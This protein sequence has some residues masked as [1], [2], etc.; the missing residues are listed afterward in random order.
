M[1]RR[2]NDETLY[3]AFKDFLNRC[4]LRNQSLLC[5]DKEA[6]TRENVT[7][8]KSR[9]VDSPLFGSDLS[10]EQKL[11][12]QMKG[13]SPEQ[14]III[15]DIYYLYFLP[16]THIGF[17]KKER[18]IR[19]AAEGSGCTFPDLRRE[20]HGSSAYCSKGIIKNTGSLA[21]IDFAISLRPKSKGSCLFNDATTLDL[22]LDNM[23]TKAD[24]AY[25]MRHA[26]LYMAFPDQYE[27]IISS[28]DKR[29]IVDTY[30]K[31][32][33]GE[34][35]SDI[36]EAIRKV[37]VVLSKRFENLNRPFDF[38]QD[39]KTEWRPHGEKPPT[40]TVSAD[41]R[42]VTV[43][44]DEE[45]EKETPVLLESPQRIRRFNGIYLNLVMTWGSMCG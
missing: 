37:R 16:S 22:I 41:D 35:P 12:E 43:P 29:Q 11:L 33:E 9:M 2:P 25:D 21:H 31:E 1:A 8:V 7:E 34:I 38:Y 36:D 27:R 30:R 26:M 19:W 15:C 45:S 5:P 42:T 6:W 14:W 23:P 13:A 28:R 40:I 3:N 39:I 44:Q 24:R 18:D 4:I 20:A 32:I 17:D 10:F